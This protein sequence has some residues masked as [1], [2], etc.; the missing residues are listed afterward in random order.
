MHTCHQN[1]FPLSKQIV[2]I[3]S[4]NSVPFSTGT[5][6]EVLLITDLIMISRVKIFK[7]LQ[8]NR[9]VCG[10]IKQVEI[11]NMKWRLLAPK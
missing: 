2:I 7:H 5:E 4:G 8:E 11:I 1:E 3:N 10:V 6:K 9:E